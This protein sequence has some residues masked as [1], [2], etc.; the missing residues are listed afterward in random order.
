[1]CNAIMAHK[2]ILCILSI[3]ARVCYYIQAVE[4]SQLLTNI[5]RSCVI[6]TNIYHFILSRFEPHAH[7]RAE[8]W[9]N[10]MTAS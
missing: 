6:V 3:L 2:N 7:T 1:M 5:P 8:Y 10:Q 4:L 9:D